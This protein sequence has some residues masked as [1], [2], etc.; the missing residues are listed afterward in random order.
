MLYLVKLGNFVYIVQT[1]GRKVETSWDEKSHARNVPIACQQILPGQHYEQNA[2]HLM[3]RPII[4]DISSHIFSS[5]P[6]ILDDG[7]QQ[8]FKYLIT[9][10]TLV[11]CKRVLGKL[12][13][14][15]Q[16]NCNCK[17]QPIIIK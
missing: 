7:K 5:S 14:K 8:V 1:Q 17:V 9:D 2:R 3:F 4:P 10:I 6:V 13:N 11:Y 12:R 16:T 15:K